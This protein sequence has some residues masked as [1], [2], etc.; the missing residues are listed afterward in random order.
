[1]IHNDFRFDNL[2]LDRRRPDARR[3]GVLDWE[4]ATVGDPLMDLGGT[5]AYW[6]QDGDD[7][8][9]QMFR[10]QPTTTPGMWTR[11]QVV[12]LLLRPDGLRGHARSSGGSTRSSGCSGSR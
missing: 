12:A 5:L 11:E 10:R 1:M 3:S 6:V 8:F 9:F 2:V 7:E 4:M